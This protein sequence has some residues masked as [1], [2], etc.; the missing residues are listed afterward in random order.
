MGDGET[1][2]EDQVAFGLDEID[3]GRTV[4]VSLRDLLFA[5]KLIGELYMFFR[6]PA[7]YADPEVLRRFVGDDGAG[8]QRLLR[9]AYYRRLW[10]VWPGDITEALND[11]SLQ[12]PS[13]PPYYRP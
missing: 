5:Y 13:H 11:H 9:E 3:P 12:C 10:G 2:I 6:R 1:T 8:A 7:N 4:Q